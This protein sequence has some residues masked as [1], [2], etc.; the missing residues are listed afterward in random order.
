MNLRSKILLIASLLVTSTTTIAKEDERELAKASLNQL[1]MN[2]YAEHI[3]APFENDFNFDY[4]TNSNTQ[5]I[6]D[7]KP[8][9]PF[10]ITPSYDLIV[11]TIAPIYERT[12]TP[13][14]SNVINGHYINGWGDI[15]PTFFIAPAKF[16][17][18][19]FGFGPSISI[20]TATNNKFIGTGK[21]SVGPEL[22]VFAMPG[23]WV[24][25]LLTNNLWSVS[26]DP[27]RPAVNTFL[28]EY[29]ISYVFDKGW[30]IASNPSITANWKKPGNQQW[31]VPFG[32][33]GGKAFHFN[34]QPMS[35]AIYTNYNAIRPTGLGPNWQ[36]QLQVEWLFN[37]VTIS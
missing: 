6:L 10:R 13:G 5:S 3:A 32:I 15:N 29:L 11:R 2:R 34:Q 37:P 14:T 20:P 7:F 30:F 33:G 1:K 21:W 16:N 36:L 9:V 31:L 22:A 28:C 19:N 25:G 12:P 27:N 18:A 17:L 23:N 24:F 8:V 26:G 35:M 4:G